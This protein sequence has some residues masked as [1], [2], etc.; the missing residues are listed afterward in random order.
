MGRPVAYP[1]DLP[2]PAVGVATPAER[3][4]LSDVT[5]SRIWGSSGTDFAAMSDGT[6]AANTWHEVEVRRGGTAFT[7]L[8]D[9]TSVATA[10][11]SS[12]AFNNGQQL[13]ISYDPS[14]AF[15]NMNGYIDSLRI[16]KGGI[17]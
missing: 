6:L 16:F 8:I 4:L 1:A 11:S 9:G 7:L 3:R 2:C 14:T 5:G 15:R 13:Y 12:S 17:S 10:T